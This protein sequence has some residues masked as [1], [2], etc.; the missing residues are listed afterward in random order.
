MATIPFR[1]F[2]RRQELRFNLEGLLAECVTY[3]S[4]G[5]PVPESCGDAVVAEME[6][7]GLRSFPGD[8]GEALFNRGMS[9]EEY[10]RCI[11]AALQRWEHEAS[12]PRTAEDVK[13]YYRPCGE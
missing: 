10:R 4:C 1:R 5:R 3:W 7:R 12:Q 13:T 8:S 9:R 6:S 11:L 2:V